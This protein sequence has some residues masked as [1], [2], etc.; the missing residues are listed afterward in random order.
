MPPFINSRKLPISGLGGYFIQVLIASDPTAGFGSN[1]KS[2]W[3]LPRIIPL[4]FSSLHS[5]EAEKR[6]PEVRSGFVH[7]GHKTGS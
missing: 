7:L 3:I 1:Y 5:L 6:F 2:R 4:S